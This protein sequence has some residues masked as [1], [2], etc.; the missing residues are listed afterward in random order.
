MKNV[1]QKTYNIIQKGGLYDEHK[2]KNGV[3]QM[4]LSALSQSHKSGQK[5]DFKRVLQGLRLQSQVC[6]PFVECS[7]SRQRIQRASK[8]SL[9]L[10]SNIPLH[11]GSDLESFWAF[12]FTEAQSGA[13]IVDSICSET[14][15]YD[16]RNRVGNSFHQR[17]PDRQSAQG[18][19]KTTQKKNLLHHTTWHT[20]QKQDSYSHSQLGYPAAWISGDGSGGS[21]RQLQCG[22]V[23]LYA[24]CHRYPDCLDR[25]GR[26]HG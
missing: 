11:F 10:Q 6:D 3:S 14:I 16:T 18:Q 17:T 1:T 2:I 26:G 9:S 24:Q 23:C 15:S 25:E 5:R 7:S 4:H 22:S 13:S 8:T 20:A 19:E 21:L 12:M